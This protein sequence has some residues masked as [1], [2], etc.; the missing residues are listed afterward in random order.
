[1]IRALK[2][3][4]VSKQHYLDY[5]TMHFVE[6]RQQV[7]EEWV[8]FCLKC[9]YFFSKRLTVAEIAVVLCVIAH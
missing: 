8:L 6:C 5:I 1:L 2:I 4:S 9:G 3:E 7:S